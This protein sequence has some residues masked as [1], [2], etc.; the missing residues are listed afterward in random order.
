MPPGYAL[1]SYFLLRLLMKSCLSFLMVAL[2][3]AGWSAPLPAQAQCDTVTVFA[4]ASLADALQDLARKFEEQKIEVQLSLGSSSILAKQIQQGAPADLFFSAN[5]EWMS[6]LD[7]LGLIE[8]DTCADLLGNA[9]VVVAPKG[10][11]FRVEP[12]RGFDFAGAFKGRLAIGDPDHVPAGLYAR[13]ALQWLGWWESLQERLTP[14]ADV[15][16][17][18]AYVER[19]ECAAGIV[20]ATDA[21]ASARVEVIATLPA[22]THAPIVYP[23]AAIK[24]P[25]R[26][27][28]RRL[29][30]LFQSAEAGAVFQK[31]G[32]VLLK[33]P[34]PE[35]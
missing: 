14:A 3:G 28:A 5:R 15:R 29:L 9:L 7:S 17:A 33:P 2:Q 1:R 13:Q 20:Y 19:G 12:H 25:R 8:R 30:G 11:G 35:K 24:G 4:A 18:L 6:Y 10:E 32:F 26:A 22:E 16:A 31:S 34:R 21:G 27:A 23:V